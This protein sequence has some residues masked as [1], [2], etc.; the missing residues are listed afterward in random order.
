MSFL[1][2]ASALAALPCAA[3]DRPGAILDVDVAPDGSA[4]VLAHD[5]GQTCWWVVDEEGTPSVA[6]RF[7]AAPRP[8]AIEALPDGRALL[9]MHDG[10]LVVRGRDGARTT[11]PVVL[12][13]VPVVMV[14]HPE[15]PLVALEFTVDARTT[16]VWLVDAAAGKLLGMVA[17]PAATAA[18]HFELGRSALFLDEPIPLVMDEKGIHLRARWHP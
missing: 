3:V 17:V 9:A 8:T 1:L 12:P 2:A 6:A 5:A 16:R 15:L 11:L 14:A 4:Y 10:T 18:I 7:D 13:G